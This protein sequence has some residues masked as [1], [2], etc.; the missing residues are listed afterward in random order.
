MTFSACSIV[1]QPTTLPRAPR[2]NGAKERI[3]N[4][5]FWIISGRLEKNYILSFFSNLHEIIRKNMFEFL[6]W[7]WAKDFVTFMG[8]GEGMAFVMKFDIT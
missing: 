6:T 1:A 5:F 3:S 7:K 4:T 8:I 2:R